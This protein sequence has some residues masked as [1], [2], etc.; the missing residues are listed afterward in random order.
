VVARAYSPSYFGDGDR[1]I[2]VGGHPRQIN[3]TK[4]NKKQSV[5][6]DFK[7]KSECDGRRL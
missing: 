2:R 3:K 5:K 7:E 4:Q 6:S 1:R